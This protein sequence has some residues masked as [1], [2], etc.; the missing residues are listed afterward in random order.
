MPTSQEEKS[1]IWVG[2]HFP[3]NR[4]IKLGI[5]IGSL[6]A[7]VNCIEF[8][9]EDKAPISKKEIHLLKWLKALQYYEVSALV[10][11]YVVVQN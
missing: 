6:H 11:F 7:T 5:Y 2:Y 1:Y 4:R 3:T 10:A 8:R 9:R